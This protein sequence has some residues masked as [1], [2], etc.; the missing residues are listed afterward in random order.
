MAHPLPSGPYLSEIWQE[1]SIPLFQ[2]IFKQIPD[3][4]SQASWV[5]D[6][7]TLTGIFKTLIKCNF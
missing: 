1:A 2:M 3:N 5:S 6:R 4:L 7:L